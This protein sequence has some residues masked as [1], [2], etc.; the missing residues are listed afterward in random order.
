MF[1][2]AWLTRGIT[3][4]VSL[5]LNL[6]IIKRNLYYYTIMFIRLIYH[7]NF[8]S[9]PR[10]DT[11]TLRISALS[12]PIASFHSDHLWIFHIHFHK[13]PLCFVYRLGLI[14]SAKRH[15]AV[16][17]QADAKE[18]QNLQTVERH[19]SKCIEARKM[20]NWRNTLSESNAAI[21]AGADS[22][23]QV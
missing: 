1:W 2:Q 23:P 11:F 10:S 18:M 8:L 20:G 4:G 6:N 13:C 21:A 16:T 14:E 17:C 15:L 5:N 3:C 19:I 9:M 12:L 7:Y 22:A